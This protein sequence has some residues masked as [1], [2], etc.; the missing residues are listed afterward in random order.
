M[1]DTLPHYVTRFVMHKDGSYEVDML[2][3]D[4]PAV[5]AEIPLAPGVRGAADG[6]R[7]AKGKQ[8]S[9]PTARKPYDWESLTMVPPESLGETTS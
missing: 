4:A 9:E 8:K 1:L 3:R 2:A 6:E 7:V 5:P